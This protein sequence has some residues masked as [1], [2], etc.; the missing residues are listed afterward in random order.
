MARRVLHKK[1]HIDRGNVG[2]RLRAF[3]VG[4]GYESITAYREEIQDMMDVLLGRKS[5]PVDLG[6]HTLQEVADAYFAR[7]MEMQMNLHHM[8][9]TG[10]VTR[11]SGP[12][13]FRTGEL[14]DFIEV[15]KSAAELGSRRLTAEQLR[16]EQEMR[17]MES[18][19]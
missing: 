8:E 2:K 6:V 1:V 4:E 19:G 16:I 13:K 15:A 5:P 3:S 18:R 14:R 11:G 12:Y 10:Q 9:A 7:G 17:G